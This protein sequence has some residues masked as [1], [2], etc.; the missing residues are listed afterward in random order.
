MLHSDCSAYDGLAAFQNDAEKKARNH[1]SDLQKAAACLKE[2]IPELD[3]KACFVDFDG[4]WEAE[5]FSET[6]DANFIN[7][8]I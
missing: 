7:A 4:I 3:V 8:R 5:I 6:Q 1:N 2:K